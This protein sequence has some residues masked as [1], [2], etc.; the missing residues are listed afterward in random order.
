[1]LR[2]GRN[3]AASSCPRHKHGKRECNGWPFMRY[4]RSRR[5]MSS[6][7]SSGRTRGQVRHD[8]MRE[9]RRTLNG[10]CCC[11]WLRK[12]PRVLYIRYSQSAQMDLS[13]KFEFT[14]HRVIVTFCSLSLLCSRVQRSVSSSAAAAGRPR[15]RMVEYTRVSV[16]RPTSQPARHRGVATSEHVD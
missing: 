15:C 3:V 8:A 7:R 11:C 16:C 9:S 12:M 5:R 6:S 13:G 14:T 2:Y 10:C 4:R 1:M